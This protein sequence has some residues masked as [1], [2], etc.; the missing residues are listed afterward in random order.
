VVADVVIVSV[1]VPPAATTAGLNV[2]VAP[3]GSPLTASVTFPDAPCC[4]VVTVYVVPV[5]ALTER[6][7]GTTASVKSAGPIVSV[8]AWLCTFEPSVPVTVTVLVWYDAPAGIVTVIVALPP[9]AIVALSKVAVTP[10]GIP[11]ADS[12]TFPVTPT[13]VVLIAYVVENPGPTTRRLGVTSIVK[14]VSGHAPQ[15]A[16]QVE[17]VSPAQNSQTLSPHPDGQVSPQVCAT[18][19]THVESHV[20][21]QQ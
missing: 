7:A 2:P 12:V 3:A 16:A 5:P 6:L 13:I 14:S 11:L 20:F 19:Q 4:V 15:S 9:A 18:S 1:E 17:Q 8:T 10:D 21:W